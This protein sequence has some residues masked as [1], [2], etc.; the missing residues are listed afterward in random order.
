MLHGTLMYDVVVWPARIYNIF[1]HFL[2][3]ARF[4]KKKKI[5]EHKTWFFIFSTPFS[6]T[7]P[8]LR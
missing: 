7:L 4:S 3:T 6:E 2:K 8:I 5:T 1:P